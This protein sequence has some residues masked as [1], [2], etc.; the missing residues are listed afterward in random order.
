LC[1]GHVDQEVMNGTSPL[2]QAVNLTFYSDPNFMHELPGSPL[3]VPVGQEVYVSVFT[4]MMD[5]NTKMRVHTCYA[6]PSQDAP[7]HLKYYLIKYG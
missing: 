4:T 2:S 3:H 5:W 7:D 1:P 6:K